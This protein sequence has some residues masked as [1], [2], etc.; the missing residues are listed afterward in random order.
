MVTGLQTKGTNKI[1]GTPLGPDGIAATKAKYGWEYGPFEVPEEVQHRFD[2]LLV[3]TG[4]NGYNEWKTLFEGYK[5]TYPRT[6]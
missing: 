1:H 2:K 6:C 3:Q 4:E 5:Q